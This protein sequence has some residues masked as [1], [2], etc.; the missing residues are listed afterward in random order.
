MLLTLRKHGQQCRIA[1]WDKGRGIP[2]ADWPDGKANFAAFAKAVAG[3]TQAGRH[4]LGIDNVRELCVAMGGQMQLH[5]RLNRVTVFY[6]DL[7]IMGA[8][9]A[10]ATACT[11]SGVANVPHQ[12]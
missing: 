7:P 3:R 4:G 5:S 6:F 2:E 12:S 9:A 1:V 8:A 10:V 11:D